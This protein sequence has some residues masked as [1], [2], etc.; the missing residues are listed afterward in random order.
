MRQREAADNSRAR[1]R[2]DGAARA[3]SRDGTGAARAGSR[4][5]TGARRAVKRRRERARG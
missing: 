4:D 3:G 1:R 2:G 5:G